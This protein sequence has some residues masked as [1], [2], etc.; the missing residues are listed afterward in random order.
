MLHNPVCEVLSSSIPTHM[1]I[2]N[3]VR[4]Q[5]ERWIWTVLA[6]LSSLGKELN[7][8]VAVGA[9]VMAQW[10]RALTALPEVLSSIPSNHMVA[11]NHL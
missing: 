1:H 9:G 10:L 2:M 5:R 11:H 3:L 7:I 6:M 4:N 8:R